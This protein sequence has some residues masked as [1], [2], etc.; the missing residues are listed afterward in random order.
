MGLFLIEKGRKKGSF[1]KFSE[2][3]SSMHSG[4]DILIDMKYKDHI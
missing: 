1:A 2:A 4:M 3:L